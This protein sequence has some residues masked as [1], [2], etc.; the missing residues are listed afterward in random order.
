[1]FVVKNDERIIGLIFFADA[2]EKSDF[3]YF[4]CKLLNLFMGYALV[5]KSIGF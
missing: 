3:S 4:I 1:M 5:G 2:H